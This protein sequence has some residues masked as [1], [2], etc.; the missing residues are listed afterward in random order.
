MLI[1]G[2]LVLAGIA[3]LIAWMQSRDAAATQGALLSTAAAAGGTSAARARD[4]A[5]RPGDAAARAEIE[6]KL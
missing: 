4:K 1:I 2:A 3:A 6:S 5:D